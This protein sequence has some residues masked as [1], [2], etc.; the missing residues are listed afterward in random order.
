VGIGFEQTFPQ[1]SLEKAAPRLWLRPLSEIAIVYALLEAALWSERPQQYWWA[2]ATLF[3]VVVLT[4]LGGRSPNQLGIGLRGLGRAWRVIPIAMLAGALLLGLAIVI[5]TLHPLNRS[6]VPVMRG[7]AYAIWSLVQEFL[8]Q[9][10]FFVRLEQTMTRRRAVIA[11][12]AIFAV[13]HI[14]NPILM[15][16]TFL[17]GLAFTEAFRRY[18]NIYPIAV[19]HAMLGLSLA[20]TIP[21]SWPHHMKVGIAYF[22]I[23]H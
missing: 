12:A 5:G 23:A 18:R 11:N 6:T 14:P 15:P 16:A 2:L 8:A 1:A 3:T 19:A 20:A 21:Y 17:V 10:F 9:S 13:A 22:L 7:S 4:A